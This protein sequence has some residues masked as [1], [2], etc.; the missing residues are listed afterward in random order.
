MISL[1]KALLNT[2]EEKPSKDVFYRLVKTVGQGECQGI[3][4][5]WADL[6]FNQ[7]ST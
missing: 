5:S 3:H 2:V 6:F 1:V 4:W 7:S